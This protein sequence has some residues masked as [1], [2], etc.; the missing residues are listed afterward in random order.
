[1]LGPLTPRCS[2]TNGRRRRNGTA[3]KNGSNVRKTAVSFQQIFCHLAASAIIMHH[4][5]LYVRVIAC[6]KVRKN[7]KVKKIIKKSVKKR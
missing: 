6:E 3:S 7:E 5:C 4:S 2:S 1:M